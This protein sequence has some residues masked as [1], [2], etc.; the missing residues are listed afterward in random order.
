MKASV[1]QMGT[2]YSQLGSQLG[3]RRALFSKLKYWFCQNRAQEGWMNPMGPGSL[4][5]KRVLMATR[6][7]GSQK[8]F[9]A[10]LY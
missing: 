6:S 1:L 5:S 9:M 7:L 2:F 8:G 4:G 3:P 10:S